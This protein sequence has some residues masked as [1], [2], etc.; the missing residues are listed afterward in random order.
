MGAKEILPSIAVHEGSC[1]AVNSNV[2]RLI[3]LLPCTGFRIEFNETYVSEICSVSEPESSVRSHKKSCI[4][5]IAVL[6]HFR[7]GNFNRLGI[8]KI[9]GIRI[10]GLDPHSKHAACVSAAKASACS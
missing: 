7:M 5:C 4:Y 3:S 2:D 8:C 9:R 6:I 10:K 1:F